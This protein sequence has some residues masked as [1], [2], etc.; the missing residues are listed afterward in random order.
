MKEEKEEEEVLDSQ[1]TGM[2][3]TT[4]LLDTSFKAGRK[5]KTWFLQGIYKAMERR[6]PMKRDCNIDSY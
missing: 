2:F 3:K 5:Q 1:R 4:N 6:N